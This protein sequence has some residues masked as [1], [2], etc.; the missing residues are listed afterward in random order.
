MSSF[1]IYHKRLKLTDLR[2]NQEVM[3]MRRVNGWGKTAYEFTGIVV[4]ASK[5]M[6]VIR[7]KHGSDVGPGHAIVDPASKLGLVD[8]SESITFL[9][10]PTFQNFL[11][12]HL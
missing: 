11:N 4:D 12:V 10:E 9:L 6:V 1:S 2:V 7:D 8:D 3:V 5:D